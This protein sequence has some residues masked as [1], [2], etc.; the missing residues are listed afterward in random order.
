MADPF[1]II[2]GIETCWRAGKFFMEAYESWKSADSE[3]SAHCIAIEHVWIKTKLQIEVINN[4]MSPDSEYRKHVDDSARVLSRKLSDAVT[5][6]DDVIKR[7]PGVEQVTVRKAK[8][9]LLKETIDRAV[10][11]LEEW[12]RRFDPSW[13]LIL[14]VAENKEVSVQTKL[15]DAATKV[16][17]LAGNPK[18]KNAFDL[19]KDLLD[20]TSRPEGDSGIFLPDTTFDRRPI[21]YST[22]V[23]ARRPQRTNKWF[24]IDSVQC[25][26]QANRDELTGSVRL[27]ASKLR[28]ADPLTFGLL[29]CQGVMKVTGEKSSSFDFILNT[30]KGKDTFVCLRDALL[31][32]PTPSLTQRLSIAKEL[33]KSISYMH[34]FDFVH[35]NIRPETIL[36]F[37]DDNTH[38][39]LTFLVGFEGFRSVDGATAQQSDAELHRDVYRHPSR[40]GR[41]PAQRYSMGHDIYS[42]GVCLLEIGLWKSLVAYKTPKEPDLAQSREPLDKWLRG[43]NLL[44]SA[45][46]PSH[47]LPDYFEDLAKTVLPEHAGDRYSDIVMNCLTCLDSKDSESGSGTADIY[48]ADPEQP[49]IAAGVKFIQDILLRVDELMI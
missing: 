38:K 21:P 42:L 48:D 40:Q 46:N 28:R 5:A 29:N 33:T 24:V 16:K 49:M 2:S 17:E 7:K 23:L 25:D 30:P 1:T 27:L 18:E 14:R 15:N 47:Y 19:A 39:N 45:L 8:Y 32:Q 4:V 43:R 34:T 6:I 35:K 31:T 9:I 22:A 41:S 10:R 13:F 26:E 36:L 20:V 44:E 3:L 11:D 37:K 12:Q